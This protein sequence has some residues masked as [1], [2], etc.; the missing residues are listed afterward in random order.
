MWQYQKYH[1]NT[2][3][4]GVCVS[5]TRE[6]KA[7]S[8]MDGEGPGED[9]SRRLGTSSSN[10]S[11]SDSVEYISRSDDSNEE[12]QT[13][14]AVHTESHTAFDP[15]TAALP[16]IPNNVPPEEVPEGVDQG[17]RRHT[18][19]EPYQMPPL[20]R[21]DATVSFAPYSAD[22][23][24]PFGSNPWMS[25]ASIAYGGT[26]DGAANNHHTNGNTNGG[27]GNIPGFRGHEPQTTGVEPTRTVPEEFDQRTEDIEAW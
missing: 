8:A 16:R 11:S 1:H 9:P 2:P 7:N 19:Q 23:M 13:E 21:Q 6:L 5:Y 10:S 12:E 17:R 20:R 26:R 22:G 25:T 14:E 27:T 15:R 24:R 3:F 18:R 4:L